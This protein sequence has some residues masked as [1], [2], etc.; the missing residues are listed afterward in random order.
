MKIILHGGMHKTGSSA[1][2]NA[3]GAADDP[4]Y[5]Y[6]TGNSHNLS[7]A[8]KTMF[9][10]S[11]KA[12]AAVARRTNF[13][14][15]DL[16]ARMLARNTDALVKSTKPT[17]LYSAE[18]MFSQRAVDPA[19]IKAFLEPFASQIDVYFYIRPPVSLVQSAFQQRLKS[20]GRTP[21]SMDSIWPRYHQ[22]LNNYK[23]LFGAD[24]VH[25]RPY[26]RANLKDG[27]IVA[28]FADWTGLPRPINPP[29]RNNET[30]S[31]EAT[32]MLFVQRKFGDGLPLG[33]GSALRM[34][35]AFIAALHEIKG[36][37][38]I[39][40]ASLLEPALQKYRGQTVWVQRQMGGVDLSEKLPAEGEGISCEDDLIQIALEHSAQLGLL[41]GHDKPTHKSPDVQA[42]ADRLDQIRT[43]CYEETQ[44]VLD[45]ER[46]G[47]LLTELRNIKGLGDLKKL[48]PGRLRKK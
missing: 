33:F 7:W 48:V 37:R 34:N 35:Q 36:R 13:D 45:A 6:G 39:F 40:A 19:A 23:V 47:R 5:D 20:S 16:Q 22:V 14:F 32:A 9:P 12:A 43:R 31:L 46:R 10:A 26:I 44:K 11:D 29:K 30:L 1:I 41:E 17:M 2:Q 4:A 28:D 3:F 15:E 25:L 8:F 18:A 21:L 38:L 27:D 24:H 42:L